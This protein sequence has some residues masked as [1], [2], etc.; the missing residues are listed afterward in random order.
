M[1]CTFINAFHYCLCGYGSLKKMK[2]CV[3]KERCFTF[4]GLDVQTWQSWVIKH[5][6]LWRITVH[7]CDTR[8][9]GA[10][11]Q[12]NCRSVTGKD[13]HRPQEGGNAPW[14]AKHDKYILDYAS[15]MQALHIVLAIWNNLH[16]FSSHS[17]K[18]GFQTLWLLFKNY[19]FTDK[20]FTK[21]NSKRI[22]LQITI[23]IHKKKKYI[24]IEINLIVLICMTFHAWKAQLKKYRPNSSRFSMT[25]GTLV[26]KWYKSVI[27]VV[28]F[29]KIILCTLLVLHLRLQ[30]VQRCTF[31]RLCARFPW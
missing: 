23:P 1:H 17:W 30:K 11:I 26:K 14:E 7:I 3:I 5:S 9:I 22:I 15:F 24:Y 25:V 13:F 20:I 2:N 8:L 19:N 31:C 12:L 21:C 4:S 29:I 18:T 10:I 27:G 28:P 16:L 6:W